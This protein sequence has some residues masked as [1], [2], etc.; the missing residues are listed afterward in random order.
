MGSAIGEIDVIIKKKP[1]GS[2][3][4]SISIVGGR[5][6]VTNLD[7]TLID[8]SV[9][10]AIGQVVH[11][12]LNLDPRSS[13]GQQ[14]VLAVKMLPER[15]GRRAS[16]TYCRANTHTFSA[17]PSVRKHMRRSIRWTLRRSR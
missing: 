12:L 2:G 9:L 11:G 16:R 3:H 1:S 8:R 14:A 5:I 13:Q 17:L 4:A 7:G 6:D 10:T 15:L